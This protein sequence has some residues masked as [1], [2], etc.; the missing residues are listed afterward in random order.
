MADVQ[1]NDPWDDTPE[2]WWRRYD[3]CEQIAKRVSVRDR[4]PE[5]R[6]LHDLDLSAF[7]TN[8]EIDQEEAQRVPGTMG[9]R[10]VTV[11]V[12]YLPRHRLDIEAAALDDR[13]R[14][15]YDRIAS[16]D[17]MTADAVIAVA[18]RQYLED[19]ADVQWRRVPRDLMTL[20][21]AVMWH[22][23]DQEG[24]GEGTLEERMKGPEAAQ[25]DAQAGVGRAIEG[26]D[27]GRIIQTLEAQALDADM[28]RGAE[29]EAMQS[30]LLDRV[31]DHERQ[32]EREAKKPRRAYDRWM[33]WD[34]RLVLGRDVF[35]DFAC[36]C[37]DD[38]DYTLRWIPM[39][40]EEM[41]KH[42]NMRREAVER[43]I[44]QVNL[45]PRDT[46]APLDKREERLR[47]AGM[48]PVLEVIWRS[49][50]KRH[51]LCRGTDEFLEK[52]DTYP[53]LDEHG[54]PL[55]P[56]Y[57]PC[58]HEAMLEPSDEDE[59]VVYG[60]PYHALAYE[61]QMAALQMVG[62]YVEDVAALARRITV[63][64]NEVYDKWA[65]SVTSGTG[66]LV[67]KAPQGLKPNEA[68]FP[69]PMP[70][71][72]K[73]TLEGLTVLEQKIGIV[74]A[75]PM[76]QL[77]GIPQG[78]T[79]KADELAT[80]AGDR[81]TGS[82]LNR[83][84]QMMARS[85][86][87]RLALARRFYTGPQIEDMVGPKLAQLW[88]IYRRTSTVGD[89]IRVRV[90]GRQAVEDAQEKQQ[91]LA[92]IGLITPYG[93][94]PAPYIEQFAKMA[95]YPPPQVMPQQDAAELGTA[96]ELSG[97][98]GEGGRGGPSAT[99]RGPRGPSGP[100]TGRSLPAGQMAGVGTR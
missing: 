10:S 52:D 12:G 25:A 89:H 50:N 7:R 21:N 5:L 59:G 42:P 56:W 32:Q 95:G 26:Q 85:T 20:G 28:V 39:L 62:A 9:A 34:K 79:A 31:E 70:P 27:H 1:T 86:R 64:A 97:I 63:L 54:R 98:Q 30:A 6:R 13:P 8:L 48:I 22:G 80:Q 90:H 49:G 57:F 3:L 71:V 14:I 33:T 78:D 72:P 77:T 75:W 37:L 67:I 93:Y 65:E 88:E 60:K 29:G 58:V 2:S 51:L 69:F 45:K 100:Q 96:R 19:R 73:D 92:F 83:I 55:W 38:S 94:D 24:V 44:A 36:D 16:P 91:L 68:A 23:I 81:Q 99:P 41:R 17:D 40:P 74:L 76:N 66:N 61:L 15:T 84:E 35:F 47:E 87:I 4:R 82:F 11:D 46:D 43:A 18:E 53:Y